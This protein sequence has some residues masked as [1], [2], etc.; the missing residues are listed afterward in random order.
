MFRAG[1]ALRGLGC[2]SF[3][4]VWAVLGVLGVVILWFVGGCAFA[5]CGLWVPLIGLMVDCLVFG[6]LLLWFA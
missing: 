5:F 2:Y 6:L 3:C 4:G 1:S